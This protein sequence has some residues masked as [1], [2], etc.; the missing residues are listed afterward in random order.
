[1]PNRLEELADSLGPAATRLRDRPRK[2]KRR[3]KAATTAPAKGSAPGV[4]AGSGPARLVAASSLSRALG[5]LDYRVP[6]IVAG[7]AQPSSMTCWATVTTIMIMWREQASMAIETAL[8]KVGN[9][10]VTKH[11]GNQGLGG[12][13]KPAFLAAAGLTYEY[14]QSLTPE[15][16]ESLLRR[17]GPLWVTTDEQPGAGFA[18]HARVM[19]GIHGDGT[20]TGTTI[21]IVD[22]AGGRSYSE[23]FA[24]FVTKYESEAMDP[25]RPLRVQIVHWP[26]DVAYNV[27]RLQG[28]RSQS[29]A[30]S[31]STGRF[32]TVDDAEFEPP[33]RERA[34]GHHAPSA[35][36]TFAHGLNAA[37]VL[38]ATDVHWAA[39]ADSIDYRHLATAIDTKA[40]DLTGDVLDRLARFNR[41]EL[42]ASEGRVVFGLRGCTVDVDVATPQATVSLREIEPNHI[43]FRC[44]IGVWNRT[45]NTVTAFQAS[46]VP[47]WEYME[48]YREH[49][50]RKANMLPTGRYILSVGTHRAKKKNAAGALVDNPGRIQG[51]LRNDQRV[52]VLRSE[53]DLT[54]TVRDTWDRTVP[55][56]NIHPGIVTPNA[57]NSTVPDFSSAG[58]STISGSS[59]S[60]VPA[61]GWADFRLALGLTNTNPRANDGQS[62]AH[63][64]L[65]GRDARLAAGGNTTLGRLRFGS[66]GDDVR[67]LQ[68]ALARHP[69][70]YYKGKVDSDLGPGT[71][72][73]LI[74]YQKDQG[75]GAADAIVTPAEAT[76][77]G[78]TLSPAATAAGGTSGAKAMDVTGT[79]ID[80][81]KG[82][83]KRWTQRPSEGNFSVESDIGEVLH[84]DTA[85]TLQWKRKS[86]EFLLKATQPGV[87]AKDLAR[88]NVRGGKSF[89]LRFKVIFEFNGADIRAAQVQRVV[90]GSTGLKDEKFS[91]KFVAKQGAAKSAESSKIDFIFVNGKWD[92]AIG[93][94]AFDFSGKLAVE[95]DGFIDLDLDKNDRVSVETTNGIFF[96]NVQET[97]LARPHIFQFRHI[98]LFDV[99]KDIVAEKWVERLN[100]W[101]RQVQSSN[102]TRYNRLRSGQIPV[103]V[104]GYA[105]ATGKEK[106][107]RDLSVR[108]AQAVKKLLMQELSDSVKILTSAHSEPSPTTPSKQEAEDPLDRR[109]EIRFDVPE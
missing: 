46:T 44:V 67:Q 35:H 22:P 72:M 71:A 36:S 12:A 6:G 10:Y 37:A 4:V 9:A 47:N 60:D 43:D 13:E 91:V 106:S 24:T 53:D 33:Y 5:A 98:I 57:G 21:D 26:H 11:K 88:T 73:A 59:V 94:K 82:I 103:S 90:Q 92:P 80:L 95:S 96:S 66:H 2:P 54:Y 40:F 27:A 70:K 1:M 86:A 85:A 14:P 51:A 45:A 32:A 34:D 28:A 20:A 19:A 68:D 87:G 64:L 18:I 48:V 104:D 93:E 52:V 50:G 107:N 74:R 101:L 58:C 62:F 3:R 49:H 79:L 56:D 108:R 30:H 55:N 78:F 25:K 99:N 31:L 17:Y 81:A 8:G 23:P 61:G 38:G 63:I 75:A 65:T 97:A 69:K 41:F 15:G 29:Y 89:L 100:G 102:P 109:V 39:D 84:E 42:A 105:S 77:L 83:F 7:L 16:W 76:A